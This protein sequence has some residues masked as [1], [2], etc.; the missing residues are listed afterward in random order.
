MRLSKILIDVPIP[1]KNQND[2]IEDIIY[3][4][5]NAKKNTLF[6]C[7]FGAVFDGSSFALSA[8][9]NGTRHFVVE[10]KL[11]L[12]DD[13]LQIVVD[14]ARQSLAHASAAFFDYPAKSL[15]MVGVT[16]TKGKSTITCLLKG[17]LDKAGIKTGIIGTI[18]IEYGRVKLKTINTTPESYLVQKTLREMVNAGVKAVVMEVSSQGIMAH[19][20]DGILFDIAVFTNISPDHIGPSEHADFEEYFHYKK[21]LF[22]RCR[23]GVINLDDELAH[24]VINAAKCDVSTYGMKNRADLTAKDVSYWKDE[25]SLGIE[26]TCQDTAGM[27]FGVK[28]CQPGIYS[29]YNGLAVIAVCKKLGINPQ[30]IICALRTTTVRGRSQIVSALPDITVIIDYAHNKVSMENIL[31]TLRSYSPKRIVCLF[32]SVGGRTKLRRQQIGETVSMLADFGI[33][34]SDNPDFEDP[35]EIIRDILGGFDTSKCDYVAIGD[36]EKAIKYAIESAQ[37]GDVILLAGKGHEDYQLI[38]GKQ[39]PFCEEDMVKSYAEIKKTSKP[40][41]VVQTTS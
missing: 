37:S 19:R 29:V 7:M 26:F 32:G 10:R 39:E 25:T 14:N 15:K 20:V 24:E 35:H 27:M 36:R 2:E 13:A 1:E 34:T 21:L 5:E 18:G 9:K 23:H 17:V 11:D 38:N 4:S 28:M 8:Y 41:S 31:G 22:S 16:G 30:D 3:N 12:P 40:K 33:I 6:F